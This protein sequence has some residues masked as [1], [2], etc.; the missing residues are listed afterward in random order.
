MPQTNEDLSSQLAKSRAF[1]R[2]KQK[3]AQQ[4]VQQDG[5]TVQQG[6]GVYNKC[7]CCRDTGLVKD[8]V[9]RRWLDPFHGLIHPET[10][11][12]LDAPVPF[13]APYV[14][15]RCAARFVEVERESGLETVSAWSK[16]IEELPVHECEQLHKQEIR[17]LKALNEQREK[18]AQATAAWQKATEEK[19]QALQKEEDAAGEPQLQQQNLKANPAVNSL[20]QLINEQRLAGRLGL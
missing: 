6:Q 13:E 11:E 16:E 10:G 19:I 15:M 3:N 8:D 18:S 4:S 9:I 14:C 12:V 7:L 2:W 5:V 1:Q 17:R 20:G